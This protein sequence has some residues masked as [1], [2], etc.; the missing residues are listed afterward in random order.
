[1][2]RIDLFPLPMLEQKHTFEGIH[3]GEQHTSKSLFFRDRQSNS[4]WTVILQYL[5][6]F[7]NSVATRQRHVQLYSI[8]IQRVMITSFIYQNT[9]CR[10]RILYQALK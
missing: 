2:M 3:I 10:Y 1:M 7:Y 9:L 4:I 5:I 8:T 6:T